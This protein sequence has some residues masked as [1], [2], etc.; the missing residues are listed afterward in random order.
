VIRIKIFSFE[1]LLFTRAETAY[2][3]THMQALH[4]NWSP[5]HHC[6]A[7]P[8]VADGGDGLAIWRVAA[9]I[10]NKQWRTDDNG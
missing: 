2:F 9:N 1:L 3:C 5:C 8:E 4:I 7:R 6:M 10:L